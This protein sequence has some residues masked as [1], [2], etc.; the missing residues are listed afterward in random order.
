LTVDA[1]AG[2]IKAG[3]SLI[4]VS[5]SLARFE[6]CVPA[7]ESYASFLDGDLFI[8]IPSGERLAKSAKAL[9]NRL[10]ASGRGLV[11]RRH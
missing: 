11:W 2:L 3:A 6:T 8:T 5:M 1:C 4:L 7:D 10:L 9:I